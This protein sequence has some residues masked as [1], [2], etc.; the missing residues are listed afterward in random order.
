ML[1]AF[2]WMPV[3]NN[4]YF[5]LL[6]YIIVLLITNLQTVR[7]NYFLNLYECFIRIVST[8]LSVADERTFGIGKRRIMMALLPI[9][10]K[11][12]VIMTLLVV[13]TVISLKGLT[14]GVIL[15]MLASASIASKFKS[16]LH[17]HEHDLHI[18]VDPP[19]WGGHHQEW[20]RG[21]DQVYTQGQNSGYSQ[22]EPY[23]RYDPASSAKRWKYLP[24]DA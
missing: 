16:K 5:G 23:G 7:V 15:L 4:F 21:L 13:L 10:F 8:L 17:D 9:M 14:V 19:H 22:D 1:V 11:L 12:G 24:P 3:V 6:L 18:H 2:G 20:H